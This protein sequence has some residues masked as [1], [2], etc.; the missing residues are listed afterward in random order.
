MEGITLQQ[1]I[2]EEL[3]RFYP[4]KKVAPLHNGL[5]NDKKYVV[6]DTYLLRRFPNDTKEA[7]YYEYII[8]K[9]L[10]KY[11]N[12]IPNTIDFNQLE[13]TDYTYMLLDYLRG[14]D[15]EEALI[16]MTKDEQY[17]AGY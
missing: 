5:S 9:K 1:T 8:I 4:V 16:Y 3:Q 10:A 7:R 17:K 11:S 12:Y 2:L 15:G 13:N 14:Q 6:D